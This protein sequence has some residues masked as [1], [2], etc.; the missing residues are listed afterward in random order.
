MHFADR[1]IQEIL[2]KESY[3]CVGL[4][5]Q[6]RYIPP[7]IR[8]WAVKEYGPGYK[9]VA[10]CFI[11]FNTTIINATYPHAVAYK[12]QMAFY[13]KYGHHGVRAFEKTLSYLDSMELLSVTTEDAKREDGGDTA[14]AYADGHMGIVD[15]I[16][17][18][19]QLVQMPS[20]YNVGAITVTPW[21]CD[22]NFDPFLRVASEHGKGFFVVTR[23]SFKPNSFLQEMIDKETDMPAWQVLA[24]AVGKMGESLR[25]ESGYSSVGVV[26]GATQDSDDAEIMKRLVP[27]GFKLKP[28]FGFQG[29]GPDEAVVGINDDGLGIIPNNSRAVS[30][31]WHPVVRKKLGLSE[32]YD[33]RRFAEATAI[34]AKN[35]QDKLSAAV[36]NRLGFLPWDR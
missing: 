5:P 21:I 17:E 26:L 16:G 31:A 9:A 7:H 25:G 29:A 35:C 6:L 10:E 14:D 33:P 4:D 13:E 32:D 8:K 28:G 27:W 3:L 12:P 30:F 1:L 23:T 2:R 11:A 22:P 18:D 20:P 19:G 34:M 24:K 15:V 36:K